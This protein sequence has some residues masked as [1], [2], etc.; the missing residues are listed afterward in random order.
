MNKI[1]FLSW[2]Y[3][4]S[5]RRAGFH[6]IANSL[7]NKKFNVV[8]IASV[9]SIF[10]LLRREKIIYE[11]H[12]LSNI[13]QKLKFNNVTS[14]VN[15][16]LLRPPVSR[17]SPIFEFISSFFFK[18]NRKSIREISNANTIIFESTMAILF[19]DKVKS[20]NSKAKII[21]RVSD[22]MEV[23]SASKKILEYE[24]SIL[25]KFDLVSV[26][27]KS[28]FDKLYKISPDN[29]K[30]HYHGVDKK[31][32]KAANINPYKCSVNIV[33]VGTRDLDF[34]FIEIA[35]LK[36]PTY[37]FHLVGPF[38]PNIKR[39]NVFYHGYM[40][41]KKTIPYIKYAT[42]GLQ[43]VTSDNGL[44]SFFTDSNKIL[45]Y[46]YCKLPIIAPSAINANHR[47]NFFYY[48]YDDENSI[49]NCI[50]QALNFNR[51]NFI[52]NVKSWDEVAMELIDD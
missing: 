35:S 4:N 9:V 3:Y 38:E 22:D 12:F 25:N 17:S 20:L 5:K 2:H 19:F 26:T 7:S 23:F 14:I 41:F 42:I 32:F 48:D 39:N 21:Y 28:H 49:R 52:S 18:L 34:K 1:V 43:T 6:H 44:I 33:F 51:N 29:L 30:L 27:T 36:F 45:Q 10:T 31:L 46:S 11:K 16:S 40:S 47:N 8:F 24:K 15:F 37:H 13:F 50:E